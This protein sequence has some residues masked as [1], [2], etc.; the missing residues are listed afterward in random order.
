MGYMMRVHKVVL[1]T[2][3]FTSGG[4]TWYFTD[5]DI[6]DLFELLPSEDLVTCTRL[7]EKHGVPEAALRAW[8]EEVGGGSVAAVGVVHG[9]DL[10]QVSPPEKD[11]AQRHP[12]P[13][14]KLA[15]K[16][17]PPAPRVVGLDDDDSS[18]EDEDE[19]DP[20]DGSGIAADCGVRTGDAAG[21]AAVGVGAA[22]GGAAASSSGAAAPP[23]AGALPVGDS[24]GS[25]PQNDAVAGTSNKPAAK[26]AEVFSPSCPQVLGVSDY[27][28]LFKVAP[29][30]EIEL[31]NHEEDDFLD[32]FS[33]EEELENAP[34]P[35]PSGGGASST[36]APKKTQ[37]H[38]RAERDQLAEEAAALAKSLGQISRARQ[39]MH[40]ELKELQTQVGEAEQKAKEAV[41]AR[42]QKLEDRNEHKKGDHLIALKARDEVGKKVKEEARAVAKC[43]AE[44]AKLDR[45]ITGTLEVRLA[46][47]T[48]KDVEKRGRRRAV[49]LI[50]CSVWGG[51][52]RS[53]KFSNFLTFSSF[54]PGHYKKIFEFFWNCPR[55]RSSN[56]RTFF[57]LS[58]VEL[59]VVQFAPSI[60]L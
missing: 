23:A 36:P 43:E 24:S 6:H 13:E 17:E 19:D 45:E 60:P 59:K 46:D 3:H 10:R 5:R 20:M 57:E 47:L 38:I 32:A 31:S 15:P 28:C 22:A 18:E 21:G 52:R 27:D 11:A 35:R 1:R 55:W 29:D 26:K 51:M 4:T 48:A 49:P 9:A 12:S 56:H 33:D 58:E 50:D 25:L 53:K 34:A 54:H 7:V 39:N 42:T 30:A 41:R 14:E 37:K 2:A 44:V 8:E 16:K 40:K